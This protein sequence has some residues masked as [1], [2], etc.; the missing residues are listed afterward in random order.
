MSEHELDTVEEGPQEETPAASSS[1]MESL[2]QQR[3]EIL[4]DDHTDE[5]IPGY[6]N[7]MLV[8][9]Y[10]IIEARDVSNIQRKVERQTKDRFDRELYTTI[11]V[12]LSACQGIYVL[13][14]EDTEPVPLE[15]PN[16]IMSYDT[17]LAEFLDLGDVQNAR[18]ILRAVF[19]SDHAVM[20]HALRVQRWMMRATGDNDLNFILGE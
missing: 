9:R 15:G 20:F 18:Q 5:P 16:G 7:P 2:R 14:P 12:L 3:R 17:E 13:R 11:D 4:A 1:L 19:A 10:G 8:A 6:S